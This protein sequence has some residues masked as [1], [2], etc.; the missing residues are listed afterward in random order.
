M[1]TDFDT[2]IEQVLSHEGG[3]VD[4]SDDRGGETNF[5]ISKSAHP[6]VDIKNLTAQRAK[7][8]YHEKYWQPSRAAAV[9]PVVRHHYFDMVVNHGQRNAV[10]ILQRACKRSVDSSIK[11]DGRIGPI[12]IGAARLLRPENLILQ[13]IK[14][15]NDIVGRDRSQSRFLHGWIN[16]CFDFME[17]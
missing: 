8:I 3:Y 1:R 6:D 12:T 2:I 7:E 14:F 4:D 9:N 13:R 10:L 11:L 17:A 5:G 16:R 15:F